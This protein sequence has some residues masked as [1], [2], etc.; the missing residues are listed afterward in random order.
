MRQ[1][2]GWNLI[3]KLSLKHST[4][5]SLGGIYASNSKLKFNI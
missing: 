2:R 1:W 5:F 4:Q 3:D